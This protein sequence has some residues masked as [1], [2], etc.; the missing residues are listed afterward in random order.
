MAPR[1]STIADLDEVMYRAGAQVLH[2][3]GLQKTDEMARLCGVGPGKRVLDVGS[4]KGTTACHLARA[5]GCWVVGL[6]RSARMAATGARRAERDGLQALVR[7][8]QGDAC[9]LPFQSATFDVVLSEC[10]TTML[11]RTAALA[12]FVRVLR[13]GGWIGDLE[14]T[15]RQHPPGPVLANARGAWGGFTTMT[16]PEWKGF[17]EELG[18]T[19]VK[20]VEFDHGLE[21]SEREWKRELGL[22]GQAKVALVL[23]A[24]PRLRRAMLE[25]LAAFRQCRHYLG[26]ACVVGRKP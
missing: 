4:G 3:G 24:R 14:L 6:D 1:G 13:P 20:A 10:T 2:P 8:Q 22:K 21:E 11:D 5:F 9:A 25:S 17:F 23:L 7:F 15:W 18:L 12:E 19:D 26:C 16:V